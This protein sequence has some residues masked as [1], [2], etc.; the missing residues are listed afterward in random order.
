M[1]SSASTTTFRISDY[2][3]IGF[4]LDNTLL[5]YKISSMVQ[6][7]FDVLSTYLIEHKGY[8]PKHLRRPLS[9][10]LDFLQ[11]GL[12]VDF[13]RGNI[14]KIRAD[15]YIIRA[16]HGTVH[17]TDTQIV[18]AYGPERHWAAVDMFTKDLL[19]AWNGPAAD[20]MRTLLD[21]FD[22]PASLVFARCIDS[23]DN[24]IDDGGGVHPTAYN[25]WPDIL[26]GLLNMYTREHFASGDSDYFEALKRTPADYIHV[27]SAEVISFLK[28]LKKERTTFLL[29]GSNSDFANL[30]ASHALGAD[31]RDLFDVVVCFAK[32][33][34]FFSMQR[35]FMQLD[36]HTER[37]P[38]ITDAAA[39]QLDTV[40][41]QGNWTDLK[42]LLSRKRP[43]ERMLYVG[44]NLLQDVY[45]PTTHTGCDA[46]A[47]CEEMLGERIRDHD[48]SHPD[49]DLLV[50][51]VWGSY[52]GRR[53]RPS[54]WTDVIRK[55][56]RI[57][58]PSVDAFARNGLA[59]EYES[60]TGE[61]GCDRGF[62]PREPASFRSE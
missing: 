8:D 52:F 17:M 23:V 14:L 54:L 18:A 62:Y 19:C 13:E 56:A 34:G 53:S 15:G 2:D 32:K 1:S 45:A 12:I 27:A 7:E 61:S 59:H 26:D 6:L 49:E 30:T 38:A 35:P 42:A 10:Q 46:I 44:D 57:C 47:I 58:V 41:S 28:E 48:E 55:H 4:D 25:V 51:R 24:A 21:F 50:S 22:M 3:C 60:F 20:K 36:G 9:E 37:L 39:L 43:V 5:R 11:K 31:W 40:Y 16:A 33:P 29:T